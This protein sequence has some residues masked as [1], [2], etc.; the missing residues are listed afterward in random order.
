[1]MNQPRV[2]GQPNPMVSRYL[3]EI[4]SKVSYQI[5][6]QADLFLRMNYDLAPSAQYTTET[7]VKALLR[8][9]EFSARYP[10]SYVYIDKP[11][12]KFCRWTMTALQPQSTAIPLAR[13]T[14][15]ETHA[16]Y[17]IQ[18]TRLPPDG[19]RYLEDE[20]RINMNSGQV[21]RL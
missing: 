16:I 4:G 7:A 17:L 5:F 21:V 8:L 6:V 1:M 13:W 20:T 9:P 15:G 14:E 18:G 19:I 2:Q 3:C 11:N 10:Y 12:G